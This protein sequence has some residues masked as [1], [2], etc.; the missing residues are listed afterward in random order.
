[1]RWQTLSRAA[2]RLARPEQGAAHR[3]EPGRV[4]LEP[5][6]GS[7]SASEVRRSGSSRADPGTARTSTRRLFTN[8]AKLSSHF[9]TVFAGPV[10]F[11]KYGPVGRLDDGGAQAEAGF[12]EPLGGARRDFGD[13]GA[14]RDRSS[15]TSR[16]LAVFS[17]RGLRDVLRRA[18]VRLR[19]LA[20]PAIEIR[21]HAAALAAEEID[22][23]RG[24]LRVARRLSAARTPRR[25]S[26]TTAAWTPSRRARRTSRPRRGAWTRG[27]GAE[28]LKQAGT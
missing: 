5:A 3:L 11:T 17:R 19:H 24:V 12:V 7:R 8:A 16:P 21:L 15:V 13:V 14:G 22:G 1:M 2:L 9:A 25:A 28:R 27:T 10:S 6:Q 26:T 20:D 4:G 23:Q 18:A